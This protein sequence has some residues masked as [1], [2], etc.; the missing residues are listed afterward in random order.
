M[1]YDYESPLDTLNR[2]AFDQK[3]TLGTRN[4]IDWL[5]KK[6]KSL[7]I[8]QKKLMRDNER[9][10]PYSFIGGMFLYAYDPK[11]KATLPY[12]DTFPLVIPIGPA[13]GGFYG[14]NLHYL[15]PRAR[16]V[17][18]NKII[19]YVNNGKLN[20]T[21]RFKLTYDLLIKIPKLREFQPCLK[22]YLS[23]HIKSQ[24]LKIDAE[25]WW[26]APALP[27]AKFKKASQETVWSQ[28]M[29]RR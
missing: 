2:M 4:S 5:L 24:F 16:Y 18:L 3:I 27:V 26:I 17:F 22:H 19:G 29:S 25:D 10:T 6:V 20:E 28:S 21:T 11:W 7:R 14:L 8:D 15:H 1:S 12:Y 9:L 13:K 23:D